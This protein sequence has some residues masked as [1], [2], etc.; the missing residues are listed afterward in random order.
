MSTAQDYDTDYTETDSGTIL[1]LADTVITITALDDDE[2]VAVCSKDATYAASFFS[3]DYEHTLKINIDSGSDGDVYV[4][5][6]SDTKDTA[7]GTQISNN[8][9]LHALL[10]DATGPKLTLI[11]RNTSSSTTDDS[12]TLA[13]GTTYYLRVVRDEAVGTYGTLYCYIYTDPEYMVL[14]DMLVVTLTEKKDF[15]YLYGMAGVGSGSG[16]VTLSGTISSLARDPYP[17]TLENTR[18][19]IRDLL[20]E[21]TAGF[22]TDAQIN[23]WINDGERDIAE[24]GFALCHIDTATDITVSTRLVAFT[25]YK[26]GYV[27]Y[28]Y[29]MAE[30]LGLRRIT[31]NQVG[32]LADN[33][34]TPQRW[35]P[36][37]T[38]IG[39]EPIPDV[40]TYDLNLYVYDYPSIEV[41]VDSAIPEI[42]PEFRP[43]LILFGLVKGLEKI[44]RTSQA[45][46]IYGIYLNELSHTRQDKI[47]TQIDS[48][49]MVKDA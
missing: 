24:K 4:W 18:T 49:D 20:N 33:A 21:A 23:R 8:T 44:Q 31:A 6:L 28:T 17:Y 7:I 25:A 34:A 14:V 37:G 2:A 11:E 10:W 16:T 26:V 12:I 35:F 1:S 48:W 42:P 43:L 41:T 46:Q 19:K 9:D 3:G 30:G 15:R 29:G 5:G 36:I 32:K 38:N 27:E 47:E 39:I 45:A 40:G 22:Y 13:L